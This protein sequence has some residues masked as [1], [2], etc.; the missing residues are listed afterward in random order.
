MNKEGEQRLELLIPCIEA[1]LQIILE[2][3][4]LHEYYGREVPA[5]QLAVIP[6]SL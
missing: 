5:G 6:R 1:A 3:K 2:M 4:R